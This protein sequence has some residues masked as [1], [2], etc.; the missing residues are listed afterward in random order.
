[1]LNLINVSGLVTSGNSGRSS[2]HSVNTD[3][4]KLVIHSTKFKESVNLPLKAVKEQITTPEKS[5]MMMRG[6]CKQ[7][8]VKYNSSYQTV[9]DKAFELLKSI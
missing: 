8:Q 2:K 6:I 1:M 5:R 3:G 4:D 9:A 7:L